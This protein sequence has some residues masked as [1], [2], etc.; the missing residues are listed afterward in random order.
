M[1]EY[2][3]IWTSTPLQMKRHKQSSSTA[4][5]KPSTFQQYWQKIGSDRHRQD[6]HILVVCN[7]HRKKSLI[8]KIPAKNG[9]AVQLYEVRTTE[10]N[11]PPWRNSETDQ[12]LYLSHSTRTI[13]HSSIAYQTILLKQTLVID[14]PPTPTQEISSW[15]RPSK[16]KKYLSAIPE[17]GRRT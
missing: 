13:Q 15:Q 2:L 17:Q 4:T 7:Q 1:I 5:P 16:K 8:L 14:R 12:C 3:N 11:W 9:K 10:W 6:A